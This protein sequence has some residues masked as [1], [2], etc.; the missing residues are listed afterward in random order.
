MM[1]E[2]IRITTSL[3]RQVAPTGPGA[4]AI[5]PHRASRDQ[6]AFIDAF[7]M[8]LLPAVRR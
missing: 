3:D 2:S 7:R 8:R 6:A 1:H 4:G 5:Q